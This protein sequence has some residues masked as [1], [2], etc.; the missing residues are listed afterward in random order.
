MERSD[1]APAMSELQIAY[2]KNL[3]EQAHL[4][5]FRRFSFLERYQW[6]KVCR[7]AVDTIRNFPKISELWVIVKEFHFQ[8]K[9]YREKT[10]DFI[11]V[12]CVCL[13]S[14][15][16]RRSD[17]QQGGE[18][19]CSGRVYGRCSRLFSSD[20]LLERAVNGVVQIEVLP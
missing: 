8:P 10:D 16:V 1:Y 12:D 4:V 11:H 9:V 20:Y 6:E 3:D 18:I 2:G 15:A 19:A 14:F 7:Q 5:Y 17:L 13:Q